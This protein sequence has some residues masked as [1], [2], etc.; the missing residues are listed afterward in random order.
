MD[1]AVL[2]GEKLEQYRNQMIFLKINGE[3]IE[4]S[5]GFSNVRV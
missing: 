3:D 1:T 2:D 4:K 5:I